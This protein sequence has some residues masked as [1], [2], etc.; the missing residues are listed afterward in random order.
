M[1]AGGLAPIR[2][3][4]DEQRGA[5]PNLRRGWTTGTCATAAAKAAYAGWVAGE[6]PDPVDIS[7]PSGARPAFALACHE[8]VDGGA[9]AGIVKDAGDDPA[10][11]PPTRARHLG[12][13]HHRVHRAMSVGT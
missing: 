6:F 12:N 10:S 7:I 2:A 3:A 4:M 5:A 1:T 11:G 8:L 9:R 13:G